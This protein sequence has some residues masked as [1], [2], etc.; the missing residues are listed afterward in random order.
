MTDQP[1]R[2]PEQ[3]LP[4]PRPEGGGVPARADRFTASAQ[5]HAT[6]GLTPERAAKIV[7]Q[8]GN[9]RWTAFL[10]VTVVA[11]FVIAYYFYETGLPYGLSTP[12]LDQQAAAQQ[13]TSIERGYNLFEANCARC[14]GMQGQGGIGP[15]LNDQSKLFAHLNPTYIKNV[16]TVGGRYVCGNPNSLM[17]VWADTNGGPLNYIQIQDL[18]NFIRAPST[19]TFIIRNPSLNEPVLDANGNVETFTGWVDPSY[20]PAPSASPFPDCWSGSVAG[21]NPSPSG[22][23]QSLPAS[24]II[25]TV[26]AQ[27]I[28]YDVKTLTAPA[29][30]TFG[31]DFKQED[32]GVGGHNIQIK[33]ANGNVVFDG[34]VLT[35]PGETTYVVSGLA[36]GT[37][38]FQCKIHPIPAMTGTLTVH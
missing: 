28:A 29:N 12:R 30:Q 9:A 14:H 11:L 24:A 1:G 32:S 17:P 8:S 36:P 27:N 16:L 38:T 23:A 25:G 26:V 15:V 5:T 33:D 7:R 6:T 19:E 4:A 21:A 31:I 20:K 18:I 37:Y 34:T 22:P 3:R 35:D 2:E 13:V 10:G